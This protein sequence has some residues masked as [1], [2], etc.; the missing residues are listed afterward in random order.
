MFARNSCSSLYNRV[1]HFSSGKLREGFV[2]NAT[3][4]TCLSATQFEY[5]NW[6]KDT[7]TPPYN[8]I[9]NRTT[10]VTT[11]HPVVSTQCTTSEW[12]QD[13]TYMNENGT[14]GGS[15]FDFQTFMV[16]ASNSSGS[17]Q[18]ITPLPIIPMKSKLVTY[19]PIWTRSPEP[20]S[21]SLIGVFPYYAQLLQQSEDSLLNVTQSLAW[22]LT[23]M[24]SSYP[25]MRSQL[26]IE[27]CT[28]SAFWNTGKIQ[29]V[30]ELGTG[31]IQ[32]DALAMS[33]PRQ[34]RPIILDLTDIT[35]VQGPEFY[36]RMLDLTA[37]GKDIGTDIGKVLST[38]FALAIANAATAANSSLEWDVLTEIPPGYDEHNISAFRYTSVIYGYGYGN[39]SISVQLAI[40]VILTYCMIAVIYIAYILITG[41]V[42]TAWNSPIELVALALQSPKPDHLGHTAVGL[43]SVE[44]FKQGIGIRVNQD[45]ELE[46]VFAHD[47]NIEKRGLR[48]IERNK[49]Y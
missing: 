21:H 38:A 14:S 8:G 43:D 26:Q 24:N 36:R 41:A 31:K 12:E 28:I 35:A 30:E 5:P 42:S 45:N 6:V 27:T 33:E 1:V 4:P 13:V 11:V 32:T 39:R 18:A 44:T 7:A 34:I 22:L 25:S 47:R 15:L 16:Q 49:E 29:I 20:S 23:Q 10:S 46:L 40:A 2:Y 3:V 48:K 37:I 9:G 19:P 17:I